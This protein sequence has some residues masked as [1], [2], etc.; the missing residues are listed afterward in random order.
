M[1]KNVTA[2]I[3]SLAEIIA[4]KAEIP[5]IAHPLPLFE[6]YL[7]FGY[8]PFMQD[9]D[10]AVRLQQI[11]NQTLEVDIPQ[12]AGMNV[13]TGRRLKRLMA[14]IAQNVPFKP[15]FTQIASV[16]GT[17]RNNIADYFLYIEEAGLIGQLRN[18]NWEK[19]DKVY[20]DNTNLLYN[21]TGNPPDI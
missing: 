10:F 15:N 7:K 19:I 13:A 12:F 6:E 16:L 3:F 4:H 2:P 14:L 1:Y 21:L 9:E 11:I 20:L 5:G 18:K 8:Y 17:S